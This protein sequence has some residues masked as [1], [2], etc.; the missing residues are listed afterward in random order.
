MRKILVGAAISMLALGLSA[1]VA[2]AGDGR[3]EKNGSCSGSTDWKLKAKPDNGRLE[4][5]YEVDSG[6]NGQEW[7]VVLKH[8]GERFFRGTKTTHG[9]SGSFSVEKRVGNHDGTDHFKARARNL[10]ND[11]LCKGRLSI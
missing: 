10:S 8:D 6:V 9:Q 1:P 3:V 2:S 5:E 4:V 11:E 7:R